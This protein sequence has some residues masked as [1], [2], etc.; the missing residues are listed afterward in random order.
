MN[1]GMPDPLKDYKLDS[2]TSKTK[3]QPEPYSAW[4]TD[5]KP[6]NYNSLI[7]H[8]GPTISSA[9]QSFGNND[10]RIRGRILADKAI[11]S[12]DPQ[13]GASLKSHVYN[14]LKGLQRIRAERQTATH[15]PENMRLN[16][17]HISNFEKDYYDKHKIVPSSQTIADHLKL[18]TKAV[19]KAKGYGE[20]VERTTDKGDSIVNKERTADEIWTD[21][22]YHDVDDVNK[23][24][25]EWSLG[26]NGSPILRKGEMAKKLGIS[27]A[28][29][30]S[31][32]DTISR[33][34]ERALDDSTKGM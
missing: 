31:R 29:I 2:Y 17:L 30:S 16:R 28:A 9:M 34:M 13:A 33:K 21:F 6:E 11:R 5:P 20:S 19:D 18:S 15:I 27:P 26:Y 23:K 10:L 32:L 14:N 22:I 4:K 24:I 7:K 12:Y 25:M 8:L 3:E 1:D